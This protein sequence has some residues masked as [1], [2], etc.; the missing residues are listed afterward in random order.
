MTGGDADVI[1]VGGRPVGSVTA[2]RLLAG[3]D[4]PGTFPRLWIH[5]TPPP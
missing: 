4:V 2:A 3:P 5:A 1:V